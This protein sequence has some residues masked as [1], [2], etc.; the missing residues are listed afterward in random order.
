MTSWPWILLGMAVGLVNVLFLKATL[1][2]LALRPGDKSWFWLSIGMGVRLVLV[3]GIVLLAARQGF[4]Q[5]LFA[6]MGFWLIR[7]PLLY[8]LSQ[9]S[10]PK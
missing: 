9:R 2:R 5:A 3:V 6:F 8:W 7:W 10:T 4:A 1:D